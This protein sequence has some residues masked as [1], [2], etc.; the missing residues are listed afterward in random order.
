[1]KEND[2]YLTEVNIKTKNHYA[3]LNLNTTSDDGLIINKNK[4]ENYLNLSSII[5]IDNFRQRFLGL[6]VDKSKKNGKD[7]EDLFIDNQIKSEKI[8]FEREYRNHVERT[9]SHSYPSFGFMGL[10]PF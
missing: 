2:L 4:K 5:S 7:N 10:N 1:M 9:I 6:F 8:D 3:L